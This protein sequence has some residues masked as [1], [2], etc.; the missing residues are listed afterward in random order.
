MAKT[1]EELILPIECQDGLVYANRSLISHSSQLYSN[2]EKEYQAVEKLQI[3]NFNV[4]QLISFHKLL[5]KNIISADLSLDTKTTIQLIDY[6][7]LK[8]RKYVLD[9]ICEHDEQLKSILVFP[10]FFNDETE[11]YDVS[12]LRYTKWQKEKAIHDAQD[13]YNNS[14]NLLRAMNEID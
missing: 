8:E 14:F 1:I 12:Q 11:R 10:L 4:D 5:D 9:R 3:Q 2:I 13:Y 7:D 6:F